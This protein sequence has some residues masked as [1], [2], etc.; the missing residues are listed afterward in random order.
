MSRKY[1]LRLF[2]LKFLAD[3]NIE[4]TIIEEIK[5]LGYDII[6]VTNINPGMP[7]T[8]V[9]KLANKEN[10]ILITNDKDFGEI[11]FRQKSISSGIILIR[12]KRHSIKEKIKLVKKLLIFYKDKVHN[13][14][15]VINQNKFRSIKLENTGV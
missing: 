8:E 12:L 15:V 10:R 2:I 11:V 14:F 9:C 3:V 1:L 5:A 4:K 7:D 13:H 6:C